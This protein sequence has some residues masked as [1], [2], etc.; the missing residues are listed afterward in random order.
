MVNLVHQIILYMFNLPLNK[1]RNL[2]LE[3]VQLCYI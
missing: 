2:I 3:A 1:A